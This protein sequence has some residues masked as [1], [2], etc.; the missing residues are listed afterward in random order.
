VLRTLR[1]TYRRPASTRAVIVARVAGAS[2]AAA[3]SRSTGS[4]RTL[5]NRRSTAVGAVSWTQCVMPSADIRQIITIATTR[6]P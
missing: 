3:I 1:S 5:V 4:A 2:G 6:P